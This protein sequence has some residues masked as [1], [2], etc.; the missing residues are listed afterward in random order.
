MIFDQPSTTFRNELYDQYKAHRPAAAGGPDPAVPADPRGGHA[1]SAC[2]VF[3]LEGY[4]A[5]DLIA[6]YAQHGARGRRQVTIVS[7]DKDLM[8]LVGRGVEMFDT[9][10]RQAIGPEAGVR[11][12]R[13]RARTRWSTCRRWPAT[14]PTTCRACRA[15]ASRPRPSCINEYGDLETLLARA[16]EIKQPKRREALSTMP[17]RRASRAAGD[18]RATTCRCRPIRRASTSASPTPTC[19]CPA[20]SRRA[21]GLIAEYARSSASAT[22]AIGGDARSR[23]RRDA[24]SPAPGAGRARQVQPAPSPPMTTSDPHRGGARRLDRR[25]DEGRRRRA[26]TPRPTR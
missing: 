21:S 3:E 23:R 18:A 6:A 4:E 16:G 24:A 9:M 10:K 5:D 20:W 19:C 25:G 8:Q 12:V 15:S 22:R 13:R 11:E 26:S 14:R 7:S 17:T 2:P 1:P